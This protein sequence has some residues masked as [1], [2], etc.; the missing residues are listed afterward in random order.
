MFEWTDFIDL[1]DR[2]K[3]SADEAYLRTAV[4]RAYYGALHVGAS[5]L[6]KRGHV[7]PQTA[8]IHSYVPEHLSGSGARTAERNAAV[9]LGRL[10]VERGRADYRAAPIG[11][12]ADVARMAVQNARTVVKSLSSGDSAPVSV[13]TL[14]GAR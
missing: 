4:S 14:P 11:R 5:Y 10:R 6:R 2:L 8:D 7:I 12:L 13:S 1:A 9:V 3:E